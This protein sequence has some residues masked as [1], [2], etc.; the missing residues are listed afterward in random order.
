M[1]NIMLSY[2]CG[3]SYVRNTRNKA[4][5]NSVILNSITNKSGIILDITRANSLAS[6]LV[7]KAKVS[8][9]VR[10]KKLSI[11]TIHDITTTLAIYDTFIESETM[12]E[13]RY[14]ELLKRAQREKELYAQ[15]DEIISVYRYFNQITNYLIETL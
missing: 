2:P 1:I 14:K 13:R 5:H 7:I 11:S 10:R 4:A 6:E 3:L 12:K 8:R 9:T 15:N